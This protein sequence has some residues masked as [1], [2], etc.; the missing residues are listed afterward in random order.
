MSARTKEKCPL[1]LEAMDLT[2]KQLKPC[3]CGYEICL[4]CWHHIMEMDLKDESGGRCPGCRSVYNKDRILGTSVSNQILKE[5]CANTSNYQKEQTKSHKQKSAKVQLGLAEEPKDPNSIRVIQRK[6]VYIVGMP[7]EFASEKVLRQKNFLG[8]YGKMK[9]III[10]N[11]GANQQIPDSGRVYVTFSREEE[12]VR[13]IQAVNGFILHGRP[14]KA[15]FGVTRYCH[16]WLSNKDCRKPNCSY[17]HNKAPAEDICSKDDVSVVCARLEHLMGI[18]TK[19]LQHRSGSTLPPP[20][21]CNSRTTICSEIS[22]DICTNGNRLLPN[23]ANKNPGLL[24]ATTPW[25]S[26]LSFD[27]PSSMANVI[28]HQRNDHESIHNNQQKLSDPNSQKLPPLGGLDC[29]SEMTTSVKHMH[30]SSGPIEGTLLQSTSNINLVS[31]GPKGHLNE[32][33]ASNNDK[34]Q[35]SAQLGNG[36]SNSKQMTS[37]ENGTSD[38]SWQ[39]PQYVSVV[40]QGQ[41]GSGRRFTVLTRQ[42]A[43]TDT[44]SKAT[45]QVGKGTPNSTK[46]TLVKNEHSDC[47]II[48]RSQNVNLVSQRPERPLHLLASASVKSHAGAEKKNECSD[49]SEKLVPGNHKQLSGSSVSYSSTA[50][51]SMSGRPMLSTLFTS[52]AKSQ[53]SAGPHNLSDSDRKFASQNQ[54]HLVNQQNT[55][56][57]N[58]GIAGASLCCSILN[59]Q[60]ASTDGKR[61]N[62]AQGGHHCTYTREITL[63]GDIVSSQCTDSIMSSRPL[64]VVSSTD[65]A[66]PDREGRKRQVCPPGFEVLHHSSDSGKFVSVSSPTYSEPC[67]TSDALVLDSCG[68]TDQHHIISLVSNCLI[69]DGD[70]T[71]NKNVSISSPLSSTDTIRMCP[72][73]LGTFSGSSNHPQLSHYPSGLLRCTFPSLCTSYQKPEYLDGITGSY[74]STGGY[75]AFCQ[76]TTSGMKAGMVGTWVQQPPPSPHHGWTTGNADSGMNCP[77]VNISYPSYT[78]F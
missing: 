61:R 69:D 52:D 51:Q 63:S 53:A 47:I 57:S 3:K 32:Q 20:S 67:S 10:D 65:I 24:P 35:A 37:A 55:H 42:M 38:T 6:L 8:Q 78:L 14:L 58:T 66:A 73:I 70:V 17:V 49:I 45:G 62:S 7:S 30:H 31:Q 76:G 23:G 71:Q 29:S 26:S 16:V 59:N 13:C 11:I 4:W 36:T 60:V 12:A 19:G 68:I 50:V 44:R 41:G 15:T 39:K 27:S 54:L 1:C 2:D 5:L 40:S 72:Q 48:P 21:D 75:D 22:K 64:G 77:Q 18:D 28:L 33:L 25:D 46:L 43:S 34:S 74:V 9:N 56:V